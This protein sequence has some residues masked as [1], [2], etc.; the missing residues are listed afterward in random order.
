MREHLAFVSG[1]G[2]W[3]GPD[4]GNDDNGPAAHDRRTG[5]AAAIAAITSAMSDVRRLVLV[6]GGLL[7][8][9]IAAVGIVVPNVLRP[10]LG[11]A[12]GSLAL[13]VPAALIWLVAAVLLVLAEQPTAA[14]LGVLRRD[15]GA[16]TDLSA[17]WRPLGIRALTGADIDWDRV[18]SLIGAA[19]IAH[20]RARR[21]LSAAV[22]A[23]AGFLL[24]TILS[25]AIAAVA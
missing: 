22:V 24:W 7:T 5:Y 21:A 6:A 15:T 20:A 10:G 18:A 17:P 14:A 11:V 12:S 16:P 1:P 23:T 3:P 4:P 19:A 8:A 2:S 9:D 13:L 25:L